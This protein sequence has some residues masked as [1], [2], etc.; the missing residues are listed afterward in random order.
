VKRPNIL[1]LFPDQH[2]GDWMP[3]TESVF[4]KQFGMEPL[5]LRMPN[6]EMLM[7][8]G[9]TFTK[10]ITPSPLCAP[11]RACVAAG[12]RYDRCRVSGNAFDYPV[13]QRT[14]YSVLKENGYNVGGVGKFDLHKKT[15][16]WGLDGW[17]DDLGAMGFTHAIDN[18]GKI[19]AINSG[20]EAPQ[21]P[22]MK[23]LYDQGLAE[24]HLKDMKG[25]KKSAAPTELPEEAYCD[26]WL[27][28]NGIEMLK[29][30]SVDQPWFLVVN[31]TG[32]HSPFD[33]TKR[34]KADWENVELP[35]PIHSEDDPAQSL[36]IRQN[37]AAMIENID[38][39]IGLMLEEIERRGELDHTIVIFAS[40]HGEM[41]GD[42]N[43]YGKVL[44]DR[45]S[46]HIPFVAA[47]PGIRQGVISDALVELQDVAS[48]IL[49]LAGLSMP[50]AVDSISLAGHLQGR[51]EKHRAVQ[52]SALK[53]WRMVSDGAYKLIVQTDKEHRLYDLNADPWEERNIASKQTAIVE[54]LLAELG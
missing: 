42:W 36:A 38:R 20:K 29:S 24:V 13:D 23:Y 5:P 12:L 40:D 2:R 30:F 49:E 19:D 10:A 3:Y 43:L 32:P 18:A 1:F 7:N 53:D 16:W 28:S 15:H 9:V 17:I 4:R 11:A 37:Y 27:S 31:F 41:L 8:R 51:T 45:G 6:V 26:N 39:N 50:E 35:Q 54:R 48:T 44:P 34:M 14:F 22:Y 25:R 21:D 47:G 52:I 33:V 46:V